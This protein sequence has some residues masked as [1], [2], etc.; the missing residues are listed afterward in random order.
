MARTRERAAMDAAN[1]LVQMCGECE[2]ALW[3]AAEVAESVELRDQYRER[4]AVWAQFCVA[5]QAAVHEL[6]GMPTRSSGVAHT[7]RRA[8]IKIKS[9][10]GDTEAIAAE[11]AQREAAA[12]RHCGEALQGGIPRPLREVV[13][14]FSRKVSEAKWGSAQGR[15]SGRS[16]G[17]DRWNAAQ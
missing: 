13:D 1:R 9:G 8:W 5:L 15:D 16:A 11:C 2:N 6:G 3:T 14:R 10:V 7:L 12:L 17:T 4:A